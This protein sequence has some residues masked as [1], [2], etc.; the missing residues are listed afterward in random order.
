MSC[1]GV[2]VC[3]FVWFFFLTHLFPEPLCLYTRKY[4]MLNKF[5]PCS[6]KVINLCITLNLRVFTCAVYSEYVMYW[7]SV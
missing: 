3:L 2:F 7:F 1:T 6:V 5:L 4:S